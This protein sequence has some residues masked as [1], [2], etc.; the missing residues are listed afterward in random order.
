[1]PIG[2]A[3]TGGLNGVHLAQSPDGRFMVVAN[4]SSGSVAVL[5]VR[6]DGRLVNQVQL[7]ELPGQPGPHRVEQTAS[8]PHQIVFDPSGQFV[9]VPDKGLD[10][11]F[12]F[13][14]DPA[15]GRLVPTEQGSV[16]ARSDPARGIWRF[17][18]S[19]RLYGC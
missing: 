8:H 9:L 5:P 4:Y 10:R 12:V 17:I 19:C 3:E 11:V 16:A 18:R 2:M 6:P 1:M 7:V 13:R 15:A 14:F